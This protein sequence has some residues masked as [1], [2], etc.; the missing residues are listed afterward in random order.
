MIAEAYSHGVVSLWR[1][2]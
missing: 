1:A 2:G